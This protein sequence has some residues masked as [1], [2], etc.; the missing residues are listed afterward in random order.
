MSDNPQGEDESD[1]RIEESVFR[2]GSCG[3]EIA[4]NGEVKVAILE[5]GCPVC[6]APVQDDA[7]E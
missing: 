3:Q 7:F 1:G 4:V 5:N 6:T 2:C